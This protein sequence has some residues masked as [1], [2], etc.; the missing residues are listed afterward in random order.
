MLKFLKCML[1][2]FMSFMLISCGHGGS[3][4]HEEDNTS[5]SLTK[6][7]QVP[8]ANAGADQ[9]VT[10]GDKVT[11]SAAKS[12]DKDGKIVF[13]EWS[14]NSKVLSKEKTFSK[15]FDVGVH[16]VVLK[17]TDNEGASAKDTL[18]I[19]VK[20]KTPTIP[21]RPN[22][23]QENQTP[24]AELKASSTTITLGESIN[25]SAEDSKDPE[26]GDLTY[27]WKEGNEVL[28]TQK[29]FSHTFDTDGTHKITL[30]VTD[31]KGASA[32]KSIDIEVYINAI[33]LNKPPKAKING[34]K[35]TISD[36]NAT[37]IFTSQSTDEDGQI[38]E[39]KWYVDGE[40]KGEEVKF[41]YKFE[42]V[43]TYEVMLVVK[44]DKGATSKAIKEII[45]QRWL[46]PLNEPPILG[47]KVDGKE[48]KKGDTIIIESN[49]DVEY[50]SNST[51]KDGYIQKT[52]WLQISGSRKILFKA[53]E[54]FF[55]KLPSEA[56]YYFMLKVT[57][58]LGISNQM[59][60]K[61]KVSKSI[62]PKNT[63][64]LPQTNYLLRKTG[65]LRSCMQFDDGYYQAGA[66]ASFTRD[67]VNNIVKDNITGLEWQDDDA[68]LNKV[69][70]SQAQ[71]ICNNLT[72][73][74]GGWR[75]P[76]MYELRNI[77][78]YSGDP[79]FVYPEFQKVDTDL[80]YISSNIDNSKY[81]TIR[82]GYGVLD[83]RDKSESTDFA[84]RC[85][86]GTEDKLSMQPLVRDATNNTVYD[87]NTNLT[88]QD[89]SDVLKRGWKT[90]EEAIEYCK[91]ST[92]GGHN[93]WRL[94]NV[95][96]L[97]S[98]V[99]ISLKNPALK[100]EFENENHA[101]FWTSTGMTA[102][103]TSYAYIVNFFYGEANP[104]FKKTEKYSVRCV[105]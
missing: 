14:E 37:F 82:F 52:E 103:K 8:H 22:P 87:P 70:F 58:N 42:E 91:S 95:N 15:V 97:L 88:W 41:T 66:D 40:L 80:F 100:T 23:P 4:H 44:D 35:K 53:R 92:L 48:L 63:S 13:F 105:R 101:S 104:W 57:D 96:E 38:V 55:M 25:F 59:P 51:D 69:D 77:I 5:L 17:V 43:K 73:D 86:R 16:V 29:S 21:V 50:E 102:F 10:Q 18:K 36:V 28:S 33:G 61:V 47:L 34:T 27:E 20:E 85:V 65:L 76:S 93:D 74:G 67:D 7:N 72:L 3:S 6:L 81:W 11:L 60:F 78:N 84:L 89:D 56:V 49:K 54:K 75:I 19:I 45:V 30:K 62:C 99:D 32:K 98:I 90:W 94:P 46:T 83:K 26:G 12:S 24:K 2:F 9:N 31:D 71:N 39:Q 1:Y 68:V 64:A 79:E